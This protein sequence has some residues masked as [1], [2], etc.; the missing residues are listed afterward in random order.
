MDY[1]PYQQQA[2][3]TQPTLGE[4]TQGKV[5]WNLESQMKAL[6]DVK[7]N[8]QPSIHYPRMPHNRALST[9]N[10]KSDAQWQNIGS[11]VRI[12][13]FVVRSIVLAHDG[14]ALT[15]TEH[16]AADFPNSQPHLL[17]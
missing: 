12:S 8:I 4:P 15:F 1:M 2:Q 13:G 16:P 9:F 5:V 10:Q 11:P 3:A 17:R 6:G 7:I 14:Y